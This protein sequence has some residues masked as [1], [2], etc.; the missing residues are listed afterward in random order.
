MAVEKLKSHF[1]CGICTDR[2]YAYSLLENQSSFKHSESLSSKMG[3]NWL[4]STD[5]VST[6]LIGRLIGTIWYGPYDVVLFESISYGSSS[7]VIIY[8]HVNY[9]SFGIIMI[10]NLLDDKILKS[11][12]IWYWACDM[13]NMIWFI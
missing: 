8:F 4:L 13:V 12:S 9:E 7:H 10:R 2:D 6:Y 11:W 5:L 1:G 3:Y